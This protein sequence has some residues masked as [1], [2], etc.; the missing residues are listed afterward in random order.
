MIGGHSG[1]QVTTSSTFVANMFRAAVGGTWLDGLSFV[2]GL[3]ALCFEFVEAFNSLKKVYQLFYY[4]ILF[5]DV[6]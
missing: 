1:Y 6:L 4:L 5:I 2:M 3:W